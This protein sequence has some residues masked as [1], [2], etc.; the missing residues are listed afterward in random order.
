MDLAMTIVIAAVILAIKTG[1]FTIWLQFGSNYIVH[2]TQ[3]TDVEEILL[4]RNEEHCDTTALPAP[5]NKDE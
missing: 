4:R 1:R 5:P 3:T 2:P